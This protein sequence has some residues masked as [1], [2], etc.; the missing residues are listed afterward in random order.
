VPVLNWFGIL[1]A[2]FMPCLGLQSFFIHKKQAASNAPASGALPV[3]FR[4]TY[5]L[6]IHSNEVIV[7]NR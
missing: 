6:L 5:F 7:S 4:V 2:P 1:E 3:I